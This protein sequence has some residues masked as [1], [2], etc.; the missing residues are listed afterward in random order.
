MN[1]NHDRNVLDLI[2]EATESFDVAAIR[3]SPRLNETTKIIIL[4]KL[5]IPLP[6][7]HL[8]RLK[9]RKLIEIVSKGTN[10]AQQSARR[11]LTY[12]LSEKNKEKI[13]KDE[14][15]TSND[16]NVGNVAD[17]E[18]FGLT[19]EQLQHINQM[20][21]DEIEAEFIVGVQNDDYRFRMFAYLIRRASLNTEYYRFPGAQVIQRIER[22]PLPEL[23]RKYLNYEIS[24]S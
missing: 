1:P 12:P 10:S 21:E 16:S 4:K 6:L 15:E 24:F 23:M 17:C 2:L 14:G 9:I 5:Q 11:Q 22:L 7:A 3:S 20:T 8:C 19:P 18:Q 13:K